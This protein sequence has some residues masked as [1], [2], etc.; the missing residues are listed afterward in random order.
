[1]DR[2]YYNKTLIA[3]R[4]KQI[5]SGSIPQTDPKEPLQVVT[6]KHPKGTYLKA[7]LH[8]PKKRITQKLQ[9]CLIVVKGRIKIDL[10]T[11]QKKLIKY[12]YLNQGE[13]LI[14]VNGGC[15]IHLLHESEIVEVKNGPFIEDKV[16]I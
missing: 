6:L 3:L 9:E 2:F 13:V 15:G 7:H 10:Y 12:L 14:I 16:L 8:Q 5:K 1:M 4:L 11:P